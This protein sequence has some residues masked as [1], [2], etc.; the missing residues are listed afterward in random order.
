[1]VILYQPISEISLDSHMKLFLL[2]FSELWILDSFLKPFEFLLSRLHFIN[3][4]CRSQHKTRFDELY[5]QGNLYKIFRS[6]NIW[7][8]VRGDHLDCS[9]EV[10][11]AG[12][13][14]LDSYVSEMRFHRLI[15]CVM[16]SHCYRSIIPEHNRALE[17]VWI[18][19]AVHVW[20]NSQK[21]CGDSQINFLA[22]FNCAHCLRS[23]YNHAPFTI[24]YWDRVYWMIDINMRFN[25][26]R[27]SD[28]F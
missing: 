7:T 2:L 12:F 15:W 26:I 18:Y 27:N 19:V 4:L 23:R 5:R 6:K 3:I 8:W 11:D 24:H 20:P 21:T 25:A 1:M 16:R 22:F 28:V 17:R 10:I 9:F 13:Q 14:I